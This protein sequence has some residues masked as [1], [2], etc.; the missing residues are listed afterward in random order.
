LV[1]K[2]EVLPYNYKW[3]LLY[4]TEAKLITHILGTEMV[5]IHHIGSTSVPGLQA[6][7]IIDILAEVRDI[8]KLDELNAGMTMAGYTPRGEYGIPGRRYFFKGSEEMHSHHLHAFQA[9]HAEISRHLFFRDYLRSHPEEAR[10]Y[11]SLKESL[12]VRFPCDIEA[13]MNGKDVFIKELDRR[14]AAWSIS[15]SHL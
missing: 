5:G 1:R 14:A 11:A 9:G 4:A 10:Q 15:G 6:K 8:E 3:P 2:V 13:Y 7:P 12:A